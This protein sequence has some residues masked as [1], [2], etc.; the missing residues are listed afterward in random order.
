MM[1][2]MPIHEYKRHAQLDWRTERE[3]NSQWLFLAKEPGGALAFW[4]M[5]S[6]HSRG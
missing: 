6:P 2:D 5:R 4:L 1:L 3:E